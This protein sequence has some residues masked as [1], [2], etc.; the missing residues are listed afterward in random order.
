[1]TCTYTSRGIDGAIGFSG[2]RRNFILHQILSLLLGHRLC[3]GATNIGQ[4]HFLAFL[5][6][7][8][9]FV[10]WTGNISPTQ[11]PLL[12]VRNLTCEA[13]YSP[14][15][16]ASI[17]LFE[18]ASI[19]LRM[20]RFFTGGRRL[21]SETHRPVR[22]LVVITAPHPPSICTHSYCMPHATSRVCAVV[23]LESFTATLQC[24]AYKPHFQPQLAPN[25]R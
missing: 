13:S 19:S 4:Y 22:V 8:F 20:P 5:A 25:T 11:T 6:P 17:F 14:M 2:F 16:R 9:C 23:V 12:R 3:S 15:K 18:P 21:L 1:M 7:V 10:A 24:G